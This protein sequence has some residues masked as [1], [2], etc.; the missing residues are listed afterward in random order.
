MNA[1]LLL[2]GLNLIPL[3]SMKDVEERLVGVGLGRKPLLDVGH[4]RNGMV[5]LLV[6]RLRRPRP[7]ARRNEP[8]TT[9]RRAPLLLLL[10]LL[11]L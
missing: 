6:L 11:L 10:L 5:E 7:S 3:V 8:S 1:F 2:L 9:S 4:V